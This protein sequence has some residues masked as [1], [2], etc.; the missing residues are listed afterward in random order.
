MCTIPEYVVGS[1]TGATYAVDSNLF[2]LNYADKLSVIHS[3][4]SFDPN[5]VSIRISKGHFL[6]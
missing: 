6:N 1:Y 2:I 5:P 3:I 4:F